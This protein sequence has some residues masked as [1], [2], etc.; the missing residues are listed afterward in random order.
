MDKEI[1]KPVVGYKGLYD[2]SN[3]GRVRSLRF[4]SRIL[5][6]TNIQGYV[7]IFLHKNK[8]GKHFGIHRLILLAFVG[9]CLKGMET[10]H[11]NGIKTDNRLKNLAW[12]T[13]SENA[14][15]A[16]KHG[17]KP[18]KTMLGKHHSKKTKRKLS[19]ALIGNKNTCKN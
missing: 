4:H 8:I 6:G 17:Q 12:I 3:I 10:S 7:Q 14:K 18:N 5:K 15:L 11:L 16:Y 2:V 19:L 9:P 13:R 1:W